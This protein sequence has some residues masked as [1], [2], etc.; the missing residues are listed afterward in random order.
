MTKDEKKKYAAYEKGV[1]EEAFGENQPAVIV[2]E[3]AQSQAPISEQQPVHRAEAG[4][5]LD[6]APAVEAPV[7]SQ[8]QPAIHRAEAGRDL[9]AAPSVVGNPSSGS[10]NDVT[11]QQPQVLPQ[12]GTTSTFVAQANGGTPVS[13]PA[14]GTTAKP[15]EDTGTQQPQTAA[16]NGAPSDANQQKDLLDTNGK[17]VVPGTDKGQVTSETD[18]GKPVDQPQYLYDWGSGMSLADADKEGKHTPYEIMMDRYKWGQANNKPMNWLDASYFNERDMNKTKSETDKEEK[19]KKYEDFFEHLG[20]T[21][22]SLGNFI[23][24]T[25]GAP[26]PQ[27]PL[28]SVA[29][30]ER[31]RKR[32]EQAQALRNAYNKQFFENYWKQMAEERQTRKEGLEERKVARQEEETRIRAAKQEAYSNY[33]SAMQSKNEEQAAYWAAKTK[34]LEQG[35]P[36]EEAKK[37]AEIAQKQAAAHLS[38]VKANNEAN[39]KVVVRQKSDGSVETTTTSPGS[40]TRQTGG[41]GR[42]KYDQYKNAGSGKSKYNQYKVTQ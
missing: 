13:Q 34:A 11:V 33:L 40:G 21:L 38:N 24:A 17:T 18:G 14:E 10:P 7:Q 41:G 23:G 3:P 28:D 27:N 20:Y 36:L 16:G 22:A 37:R 19:D 25:R 15:A 26:N 35:L 4:R 29:L 12:N 6:A 8:P 1:G 32:R 39:G 5:E 9:D 30:T 2:V 31:Q 42:G